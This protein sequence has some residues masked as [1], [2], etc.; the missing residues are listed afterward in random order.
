VVHTDKGHSFLIHQ[1][2]LNSITTVTPASNMSHNWTKQHDIPVQGNKTVQEIYNGAGGRTT[3]SY[4]NYATA[5]TCIGAA[6]G[7]EKALK[8]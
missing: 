7:A 6:K 4:I 3:N 8:K 1:P 5:K 2:G